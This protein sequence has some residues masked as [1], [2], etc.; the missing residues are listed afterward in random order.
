M[1]VDY[2]APA[3]YLSEI[4][5][6]V[7]GE[8]LFV[9]QPAVFVRL[10][11]CNL[12]CCYCDTKYAWEEPKA[13]LVHQ[14]DGSFE[15]GNPVPATCPGDEPVLSPITPA[16]PAPLRS[17]GGPRGRH[18]Y[19]DKEPSRQCSGGLVELI[20]DGFAD[21]PTVVFTGGEPLL[22]PEFLVAAAGQLRALGYRIHLETNGT[23]ASALVAV[24]NAVDFICMD[25]K[26]P[27][28]QGGRDLS[29]E[30]LDLLRAATGKHLVV[31]I[32]VTPDSGDR[33]IEDAV[34]L[35]AAVNRFIPVF[36]QP[37]FEESRPSVGA[38]R[39]A[40][41]LAVARSHVYDARLSI[42]MHK[43]IGVR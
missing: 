15:I 18:M 30:H 9:G 31:K 26:L 33:E 28:S 40:A 14:A 5:A 29:T 24:K 7:E 39:L 21:V 41:A 20:A 12:R 19:G 27:S 13:A 17:S 23:L 2:P 8:G 25:I 16:V 6:S 1:S 43:V 22:Q 37:A 42:Q 35:V 11:G 38:E 32:V 4:F 10:A 36:L 34:R 3:A